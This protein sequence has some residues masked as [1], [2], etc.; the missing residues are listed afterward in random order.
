MIQAILRSVGVAAEHG[1]SR[2][3]GRRARRTR[4]LQ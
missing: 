1:Q 2:T 3:A 4:R